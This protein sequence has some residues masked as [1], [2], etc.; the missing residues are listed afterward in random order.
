MSQPAL[1][2]HCCARQTLTS[3]SLAF[4]REL[5]TLD[6]QLR[7]VLVACLNRQILCTLLSCADCP[8]IHLDNAIATPDPGTVSRNQDDTTTDIRIAVFHTSVVPIRREHLH[9]GG[10]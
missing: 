5:P 8:V 1:G 9:V 4:L 6:D 2:A 7:N 10:V 3:K